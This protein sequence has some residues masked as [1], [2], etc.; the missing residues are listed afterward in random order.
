MAITIQAPET[1]VRV[2]HD[3]LGDRQI[4]DAAFWGIHTLRAIEN[5][6]I[7]GV[8]LASYPHFIRALVM[9]K[10]AAA[11]AN[12]D[13]LVLDP[14]RADAIK[15]ACIRIAQGALHDQ[16]IVDMVQGGAGTSTN[17]N[18][19]EVDRQSARSNCSGMRKRRLHRVAIRSTM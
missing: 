1:P 11:L 14:E 4:P 10:Q 2:E 17:M 7:S 12:R 15:Q 8:R 18:A 5:F 9:V 6:P 13:L 19:N 3:L 16:F